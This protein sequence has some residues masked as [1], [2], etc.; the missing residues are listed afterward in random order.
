[1]NQNTEKR[2]DSLDTL[3][4]WVK[5]NLSFGY[6][7]PKLTIEEGEVVAILIKRGD[8]EIRLQKDTLIQTNNY[9][10]NNNSHF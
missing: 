6:L 8:E 1:M 5:A 4:D 7:K 10:K 9:H 3:R 2:T